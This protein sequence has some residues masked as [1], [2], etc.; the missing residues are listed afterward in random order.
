[1]NVSSTQD[2]YNQIKRYI[3]THGRLVFGATVFI[4]PHLL[5]RLE[6]VRMVG[7]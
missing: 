1:M 2:L 7:G 6:R 4:V 3:R 5:S